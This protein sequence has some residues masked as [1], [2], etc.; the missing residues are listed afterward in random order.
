MS[1]LHMR[2]LKRLNSPNMQPVPDLPLSSEFSRIFPAIQQRATEMF[3]SPVFRVDVIYK[4]EL[5]WKP[6]EPD[7]L[8][9]VTSVRKDGCQLL[10]D[11]PRLIHNQAFRQYIAPDGAADRARNSQIPAPDLR[12]IIERDKMFEDLVSHQTHIIKEAFRSLG[13]FSACYTE[14]TAIFDRNEKFSI[15]ALIASRISPRDLEEMIR[16]YNE[17]IEFLGRIEEKSDVGL[18]CQ[19]AKEMKQQ[20]GR[21]PVNCLLQIKGALP[22]IARQL[23]DEFSEKVKLA[24]AQLLAPIDDVASFVRYLWAAEKY[25]TEQQDFAARADAIR[26]FHQLASNLNVPI[27]SEE[28][29]EFQSLLPVFDDVK[30]VLS[31][32]SDQKTTL[33]PKFSAQLD[34]LIGQLH[35]NVLDVAQISINPILGSAATKVSEAQEFLTTV[36]ARLN[37]V[38]TAAADYNKYQRAMNL[39]ITR[40]EDVEELNKEVTLKNLLW[41]TKVRWAALTS[42]WSDMPFAAVDPA[43]MTEELREY[44]IAANKC[45]KG[46]PGNVVAVELKASVG[47]YTALLPVVTDLKNPALKQR[48]IEQITSLLGCNIFGDEQFRF[49]RLFELR[50]FHYVDQ[51]AAISAQATNEQALHDMLMNVQKMVDKLAF[52]M[53]QYKGQKNVYTFG[54]FDD[55]LVQ[56][57]EAQSIVATV[58]SSRYIAALRTHADEWARLLRD[59]STTLDALMTCQRGWMYLNNVFSSGDIQHQLAEEWR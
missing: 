11:V 19:F 52:V 1:Q 51:I 43:A 57:D 46:L 59:F 4:G 37:E 31:F 48:F 21:S 8:A 30:R 17:Q 29:T 54:G 56:L 18:F 33:M 47:D 23:L 25:S 34:K 44:Q 39:P 10:Y 49:G 16:D 15:E 28:Q 35:S 6:P 9:I 20:F 27:S 50:A 14:A 40:F 36:L 26:D 42:R 58:R 13:T 45:A 38:K 7:V 3:E 22:V 5:I 55:I 41:D 53:T 32:S 12:E 2:G 24:H